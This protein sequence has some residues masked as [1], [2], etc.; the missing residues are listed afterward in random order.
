ILSQH[1][2]DE[3]LAEMRQAVALA[4][5]R[6]ELSDELGTLLAQRSQSA[7]AAGAFK[8]AIRLQPGLASAHFH[9]GVIRLQQQHLEEADDELGQAV[10]LN[11]QMRAA[12]N[13]LPEPLRG[14]G[15][16]VGPGR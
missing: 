13:Y 7:E 12:H 2:G 4:P 3:T 14:K 9:L 1:P 10:K 5:Q 6:A 16:S 15:K 11:P 8:E